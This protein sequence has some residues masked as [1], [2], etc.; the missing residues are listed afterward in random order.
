[1]TSLCPERPLPSSPSLRRPFNSIF[2]EVG[3]EEETTTFRVMKDEISMDITLFQGQTLEE[4]LQSKG[5]HHQFPCLL[6]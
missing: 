4:D 3:K 2:L 1:M 5:F 6:S